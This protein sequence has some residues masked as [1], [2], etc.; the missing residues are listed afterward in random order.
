MSRRWRWGDSPTPACCS[1]AT[2]AGW[3]AA[4]TRIPARGL[5]APHARRAL[6]PAARARAGPPA[7]RPAHTALTALLGALNVCSKE[8]KARCYDGEVKGLSVV[9]P[10]VG[11][12]SDMPA[13]ATVLRVEHGARDGLLLAEGINPFFSDLD[14]YAMM[15][16]VIDEAV[17]RIVSAGGSP[18]EIA[19]LDNFCWPDPVV[20]ERNPDGAYKMAQLVRANRALHDVTIA[21]G[22]P[23]ISGKDSM[24]NDSLR[25]GVK[26]SIPPTVLFSTIGRM[27]EVGRAVTMDVKRAGDAVYVLGHTRAELGASEY[28]RWLARE[29]GTPGAFGGVPPGL[30]P[31]AALKLYRALHRAMGAGLI[32]SSHTPTVGGLAVALALTALGGDLG[33]Q[34]DL[35]AAPAPEAIDDDA[36][37]F[38]ESNSRFV[39]TCAPGRAGALEACFDGLP[40]ARIGTVTEARELHITGARGR[41]LVSR[42][43]DPLRRA[44]RGTLAGL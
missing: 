22:V 1:S 15:A 41:R 24:K 5:S 42:S 7:R 16:S 19:G 36:R 6:D 34:A 18:D 28:H 33:I 20:S 25:G 26:I 17:R 32:R 23:C 12:H 11:V 37:L 27:E 31:A 13:D 39:V 4:G 43:L 35:T 44:F 21:Y 14:T 10:F 9:K 3:S 38:S 8:Y 2:T 30:D 29:Q 40:C